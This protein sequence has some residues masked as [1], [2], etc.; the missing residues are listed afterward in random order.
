MIATRI[1]E[2]VM[3]YIITQVHDTLFRQNMPTVYD[4]DVTADLKL[5]IISIVTYN[6]DFK[7]S[8]IDFLNQE[9]KKIKHFIS[10]NI[11]TK[12]TPEIRFEYDTQSQK[13]Q[14]VL[15]II[16]KIQN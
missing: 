1:K 2:L 9:S 14:N 3:Q 12:F 5:A 11:N 6:E 7:K 15:D 16:A 8:I 10:K 13:E 4:V